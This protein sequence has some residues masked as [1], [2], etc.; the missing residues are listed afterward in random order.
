MTTARLVIPLALL[1]LSALQASAAIIT[2]TDRTAF[3]S[4]L[5]SLFD[6][7][8]QSLASGAIVS[9]QTFAA[10]GFSYQVSSDSVLFVVDISGDK[11]IAEN[12]LP[13]GLN[14]INLSSSIWAL[15]G[16]FFYNGGAAV[17]TGDGT[18]TA[19]D[20]TNQTANLSVT[21]PANTAT[22]YGFIST[23]GPLTSV[24][25]TQATGNRGFLNVD[26]LIVGTSVPEP[27]SAALTA[28]GLAL[29]VAFQ[30]RRKSS[31]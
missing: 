7:D 11:S 12:T 13:N 10:N 17:S 21:N 5:S 19:T 14:F 18:L 8:F 4:N 23:S 27:A 15:G 16:Y 26:D 2:Y 24:M 6:N 3:L 31:R 29:A 20:A 9:P 25:F 1:L 22:F 28:A 30:Q